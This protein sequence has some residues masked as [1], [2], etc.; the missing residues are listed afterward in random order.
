MALGQGQLV[1]DTDYTSIYNKIAAV[2]GR[3]DTGYGQTMAAN[4][5]ANDVT[6]SA[7]EWQNL[8]NY[9]LNSRVHQIG[10]TATL[11]AIN[12]GDVITYSTGPQAINAMADLC[13]TNNRTIHSSQYSTPAEACAALHRAASCDCERTGRGLGRRSRRGTEERGRGRAP[14][15]SVQLSR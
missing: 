9:V 3:N 6:I 2:Y 1:E 7:A 14:C 11:T 12:A 8:R 10:T 5:A 13:V 15:G 4:P